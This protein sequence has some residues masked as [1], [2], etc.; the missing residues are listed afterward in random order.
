MLTSQLLG[1]RLLP[2]FPTQEREHEMYFA[3][4]KE[5]L[6][7][8]ISADHLKRKWAFSKNDEDN[9]KDESRMSFEKSSIY[10]LILI[11]FAQ[12]EIKLI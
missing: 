3:K 12:C 11:W 4:L 8:L 6:V 1:I 2:K 9:N 7:I 10:S 5:I